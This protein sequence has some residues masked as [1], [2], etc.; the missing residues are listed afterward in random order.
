MMTSRLIRLS[1]LSKTCHGIWNVRQVIGL[2]VIA[3]P[4]IALP[5]IAQQLASQSVLQA[6]STGIRPLMQTCDHPKSFRLLRA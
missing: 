5:V 2:P 4:V 6:G 3:L 1:N